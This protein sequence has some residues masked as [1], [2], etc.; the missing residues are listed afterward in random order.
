[1][2]GSHAAPDPEISRQGNEFTFE[3]HKSLTQERD[4]YM[5]NIFIIQLNYNL[6]LRYS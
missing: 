1:M 3:V 5:Q 6:L 4:T 2:Q